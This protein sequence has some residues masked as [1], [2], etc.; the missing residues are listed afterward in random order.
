MLAGPLMDFIL[1]IERGFKPASTGELGT[2]E[3]ASPAPQGHKKNARDAGAGVMTVLG[4]QGGPATAA[5]RR[6][7]LA[8]TFTI[9]L[10]IYKG[11]SGEHSVSCS[12]GSSDQADSP[13]F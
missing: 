12:F 6:F 2:I 9:L 1:P 4:G 7:A 3:C 11:D 10:D 13:S 5:G 8:L